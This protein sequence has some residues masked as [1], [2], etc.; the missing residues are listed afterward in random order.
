VVK[1]KD[2]QSLAGASIQVPALKVGTYTNERGEY[3]LELPAGDNIAISYSYLGYVKQTKLISLKAGENKVLVIIL[4]SRIDSLPQT[5][6]SDKFIRDQPGLIRVDPKTFEFLPSTSG[7]IEAY[8]KMLGANSNNELSSQYSVRGGNFDENLIYVN[9]FEI[10]RPFLIRSGQQEGLSFINP[11][12]VGS[13]LFSTGGFQ[14]KYGDKLSSVLDVTYKKPKRFAASASASLLGANTH[15]EGR[16]K[17]YRWSYLMGAR[18]RTNRYLLGTLDISGQYQPTFADLQAL[19]SY[20]LSEKTYV[21]YLA[22]ASI[23]RY[24]FVP[25]DRVTTFGFVKRVL[26]LNIY[27]DGAEDNRFNT[28]MNGIAIRH[29]PNKKLTLKWLAAAYYNREDERF[30]VTGDYFIGE[31]QTDIGKSDFGQILYALGVGT[32]QDWGRNFLDAAIFNAGHRGTYMTKKH[33]TKW[34]LTAQHEYIHDRL[35]EWQILDSAGYHLPYSNQVISTSSYVKS[36]NL[37]ETNRL[38]GFIQDTWDILNDSVNDITVTYGARVNYWSYN[39]QL[40]ISPRFQFSWQPRQWRRDYV[41]RAAVGSYYQPPFY[42]ELRRL[43]GSLNTE[44]RAQR[45][46]HIVAGSDHNFILWNRPFKFVTEAYYKLLYDV[47]TYELD[48]VRIRYYANNEAKGFARGIDFRLNGELVKDAESWVSLSFLDTRE[49]L[50]NDFYYVFDTT[51][52]GS[53]EIAKI[54]TTIKY[55]GYIPRPTDQRLTFALFMQ[56]YIP[57]NDRFKVHLNLIFA[58]GLPVGPPDLNRY[59]DTLRLPPYRRVD[60]G[61]SAMLLGHKKR[62]DVSGM[63]KYIRTLWVSLEV[64]NLLGISNTISYLWIKDYYNTTYAVPNYLT[65]RRLNLRIQAN[66]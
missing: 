29:E 24:Y 62:N 23:N 18:Y 45:S 27:F 55:P 1:N 49:D 4:E 5:V 54:D 6:I 20:Q 60:I 44:I 66:F 15:I 26:R 22:N 64:F 37:L 31:V 38:H 16:S 65:T 53:G 8:L 39:N 3:E 43:D 10:Y 58:T 57:G 33:F 46:Y 41:F 25:E 61:F 11:D 47:N 9:D 50:K 35:L 51:F 12:L 19:I 56:D 30:D 7:G 42:R 14:A 17:N 32:T 48:N 52:T 36:E 34:G 28:F 63:N 2:Q 21:E 59:R 13:I 40:F